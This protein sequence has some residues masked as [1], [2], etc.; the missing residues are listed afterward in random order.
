MDPPE[1]P[2]PV[3]CDCEWRGFA[4]E[5]EQTNVE[6]HRDGSVTYDVACPECGAVLRE[7]LLGREPEMVAGKDADVFW[8]ILE[9]VPQAKPHECWEFRGLT[10]QKCKDAPGG[11]KSGYDQMHDQV[12]VLGAGKSRAPAFLIST[13]TTEGLWEKL[14]TLAEEA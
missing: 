13:Y 4:D 11:N 6:E 5:L 10:V 2:A 1:P 12:V 14:T 3:E 9:E 8:A 7:D